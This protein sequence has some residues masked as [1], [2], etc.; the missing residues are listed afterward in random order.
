LFTLW[1]YGNIKAKDRKS[2]IHK[3]G[4]YSAA[5]RTFVEKEDFTNIWEKKVAAWKLMAKSV[6]LSQIIAIVD[7]T[8]R[9]LRTW[10]KE[11][12]GLPPKLVQTLPPEVQEFWEK[13]TG[14]ELK[15]LELSPAH[16]QEPKPLELSP[17]HERE[18]ER[19]WG[20]L[21]KVAERLRDELQP[22]ST[23]DSFIQDFGVPGMHWRPV[24]T[25]SG[26][27]YGWQVMENGKTI[28]LLCPVEGDGELE[29]PL[30]SLT[31]HLKNSNFAMLVE[32]LEQRRLMGGN[33]LFRCNSLIQR[34]YTDIKTITER[35]DA[36]FPYERNDP[37]FTQ[38]FPLT[39]CVIAIETARGN[40]NFWKLK[41]SKDPIT[42]SPYQWLKYGDYGIIMTLK[43]EQLDPY[44][45]L[46]KEL[47]DRYTEGRNSRT[48]R[49]IAEVINKLNNLEKRITARLKTFCYTVPLPGHCELCSKALGLE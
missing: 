37:G 29:P 20:D 47:I 15:P 32:L 30:E 10:K 2:D 14:K 31:S 24:K 18:L 17:A 41:Y 9:T 40:A 11:L 19:H 6:P 21:R 23:W 16:E 1:L 22:P 45:K 5:R 26:F 8:D 44:E 36:S 28:K 4:N 13:E 42:D 35:E 43:R 33:Y 46:H 34:V 12:F 7:R 38:W 27:S 25:G 39:I 3:S 49:S 48:A